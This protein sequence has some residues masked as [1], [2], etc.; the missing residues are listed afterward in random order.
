MDENA[1]RTV[2]ESTALTSPAQSYAPTMW[3]DN[4]LLAQAYKAAQYLSSSDL[5][6]EQT[7]KNKPQNC[8]IALDLANRINMSPL[9]VMQNLY[10]VKG[11]PAWSGQFCVSLINA[12]GRFSP[13]D[14][15]ATENGMFC[16]AARLSDGVVL[17]GPE[18]TWDMVK[19]E[20]WLDKNGS[21][22]KTMPQLMFRYRAA[23]FFARSYCPE[24]LMG[25]QTAEE[26]RDVNG[27]D[28]APAP[29]KI[30]IVLE[31]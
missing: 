29:E 4:K 31:E 13:L 28:D 21:K 30:K 17:T 9:V 24:L 2:E 16:K 20:G 6:P 23:A 26:V 5:V 3:T 18:V 12:C 14:F 8:L 7:Y 10:I 11:K 15:V 22:W 25:V 1:N 27:Y 19:S